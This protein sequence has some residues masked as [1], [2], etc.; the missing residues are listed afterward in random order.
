LP[1]EGGSGCTLT[2]GKAPNFAT[3]FGVFFMLGVTIVASRNIAPS[4]G[5]AMGALSPGAP[6]EIIL[7]SANT[8]WRWI[9]SGSG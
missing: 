8:R 3:S 2:S 4:R 5:M 1:F 6:C 9:P 7:F